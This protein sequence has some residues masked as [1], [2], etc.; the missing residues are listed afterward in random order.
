MIRINNIKIRKDL[1]EMQILETAIHKASIDKSDII[2]WYISKKSIDARKK[3]DIHYIFNIDLTLKD[4][5]KYLKRK[6]AY[7]QKIKE[8]ESISIS[9]NYNYKHQPVIIGAGP[10]GLFAALTFIQNGVKPIIIEQ[11][12]NV[13]ERKKDVDTFLLT[14]KLNPLSNVQFGEGGAGTFSDG[15]LTTGINNPLCQKVLKE[16]YSITFLLYLIF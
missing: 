1:S 3:D 2:N 7:I 15:K 4:E 5:N 8:P 6:N 16:F 12:K 11:G 9:S 13:D 14:G 10:A